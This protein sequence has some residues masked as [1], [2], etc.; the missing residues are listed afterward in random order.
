MPKIAQWSYSK[1]FLFTVA[2]AVSELL[3]TPNSGEAHRF[4]ISLLLSA[5]LTATKYENLLPKQERAI[6]SCTHLM[7][8]WITNKFAGPMVIWALKNWA[9]HKERKNAGYID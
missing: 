6:Y 2:G 1:T 7:S 5:K 3:L 4:P 9:D 8:I